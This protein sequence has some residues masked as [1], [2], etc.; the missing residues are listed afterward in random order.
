M[1]LAKV[2]FDRG[3]AIWIAFGMI[4][5]VIFFSIAVISAKGM[6]SCDKFRC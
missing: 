5:A 4:I 1:K 3:V 2:Y 6:T